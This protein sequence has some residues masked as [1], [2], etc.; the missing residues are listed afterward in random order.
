MPPHP[1]LN[2]SGVCG[3]ASA[4]VLPQ[5]RPV[6]RGKSRKFCASLPPRTGINGSTVIVVPPGVQDQELP[7]AAKKAR[8]NQA[9]KL[10]EPQPQGVLSSFCDIRCQ[11][12]A[13]D[14][15]RPAM[16][17][18]GTKRTST[19]AQQCLLLGVR[20]TS[21]VQS[22]MSAFDPQETSATKIAD[23]QPLTRRGER[24]ATSRQHN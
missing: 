13:Y 6:H 1:R 18:F 5:R 15:M 4:T 3:A 16:S 12:L 20:R 19:F 22:V 11:S 7:I 8:V 9:N 10:T 24:R 14:R 17:A 23:A 2:P 21:R